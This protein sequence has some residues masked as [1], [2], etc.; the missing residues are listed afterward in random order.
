MFQYPQR[1]V[2]GCND[3]EAAVSAL[4]ALFQYPQRVVGGCNRQEELAD[5]QEESFSTL[6]GS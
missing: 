2:G 6:S 1:V 3:G 4:Q 5:L